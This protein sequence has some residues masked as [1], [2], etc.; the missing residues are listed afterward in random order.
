MLRIL[1]LS[2]H[3][4]VEHWVELYFKERRYGYLTSNIAESLNSWLL[5]AREKPVLAMLEHIRQQLMAWFAERRT[6][7]D[8]THGLLVSKSA[9]HLQS[10]INDRARRY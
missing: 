3:A 7:E 2:E 8:H 5:E 4:Q 9:E 1:T 10:V 6:S